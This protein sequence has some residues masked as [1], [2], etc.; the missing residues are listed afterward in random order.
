MSI[1]EEFDY[2]KGIH[3]ITDEVVIKSRYIMDLQKVD[4]KF[5]MSN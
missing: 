2:V 4:I 3:K 5:L 1:R